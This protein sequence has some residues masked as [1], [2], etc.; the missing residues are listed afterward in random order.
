MSGQG[1]KKAI[2]AA[3]SANLG[4]AV[5][6]FAG[7]L[8]TGASSM[9]AE[10]IHS[11]ADTGNQALLILGNRRAQRAADEAHPFGY[12]RERY[13]WAFVVAMVLFTL[14]SLFALIEGID[15]IEHPEP[16]ES[17]A[18][19]LA[20][21]GVAIVLEGW[22]LRTAVHEA[23]PSK[24]SRGWLRFVHE[25]KSPEL[26][27]LL[28]EDLAAMIGLVI[29]FAALL[30]AHWIDPVFD[31]V[32]TVGIGMILGGVAALLAVEMKS[33]LLGESASPELQ[34]VIE[35]A[36]TSA[37]GVDALIHLR[38]EHVGPDQLLIGAKVAFHTGLSVSELAA[39]IDATEAAIRSAVPGARYVY[40]EPDLLRDGAAGPAGPS[41]A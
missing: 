32:G 13:F 18:I 39:A 29:A 35:T 7:F 9:L 41:G 21:L 34:A 26:P 15:K 38:T 8:V 12:G 2:V 14:G 23:R 3:F 11:L 40:L 4:I 20:V 33:L 5:A 1:S 19:A 28:L 22:S 27:V 36:I 25:S 31:G 30:A 16:V 37:P 24:G 10:S 17:V 6:K